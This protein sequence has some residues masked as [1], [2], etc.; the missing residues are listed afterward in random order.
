MADMA[1]SSSSEEAVTIQLREEPAP[2]K[3]KRQQSPAAD[4]DTGPVVIAAIVS[5]HGGR[6]S[7][8]LA[9]GQPLRAAMGTGVS[10]AWSTL[11]LHEHPKC[12][13]VAVMRSWKFLDHCSDAIIGA[14]VTA[15]RRVHRRSRLVRFLS[16]GFLEIWPLVQPV[17]VDTPANMNSFTFIDHVFSLIM[18]MEVTVGATGVIGGDVFHALQRSG[19]C[20]TKR[21]IWPLGAEAALLVFEKKLIADVTAVTAKNQVS[22]PH[23]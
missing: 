6:W 5:S 21:V 4:A 22:G 13:G 9:D 7:A 3:R 11:N 17:S 23:P 20:H 8:E 15:L 16:H 10:H 18:N 14:M 1:V 19:H 2:R 12:V